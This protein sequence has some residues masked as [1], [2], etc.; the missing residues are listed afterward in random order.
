MGRSMNLQPKSEWYKCP[1]CKK[2]FYVLYPSMWVYRRD[3]QKHTRLICSWHCCVAVDKARARTKRPRP[4]PIECA[5]PDP[6]DDVW[7]AVDPESLDECLER[8]G[9]SKNG[10]CDALGRSTTYILNL[11]SGKQK[12]IR[13]SDARQ[14]AD[15]LECRWDQLV[16]G[17]GRRRTDP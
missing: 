8:S 7:Y 10:L 15:I 2:D 12:K 1:V 17:P 3:I 16:T 5:P 11:L 13:L 14:M 4:L 6:K 9:V